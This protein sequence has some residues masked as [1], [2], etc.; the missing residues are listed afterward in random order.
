MFR[1]E[2]ADVITNTGMVPLKDIRDFLNDRDELN[3]AEFGLLKLSYFNDTKFAKVISEKYKLTFIDL[4]NA[5]IPQ[6]TL[7]LIKKKDVL[8][9]QQ[10]RATLFWIA[11]LDQEHQPLLL[12]K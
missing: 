1:K 2:F 3:V 10:K 7:E 11:F 8:K 5:K 4:Y 9:Y 12:T 6:A